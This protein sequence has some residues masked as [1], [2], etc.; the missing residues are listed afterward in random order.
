M[1]T[2]KKVHVCSKCINFFDS[3]SIYIATKPGTMYYTYYCKDC[4]E[5]LNIVDYKTYLKP[6]VSKKTTS[7]EKIVKLKKD[8]I[9]KAK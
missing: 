5:S 3:K 7:K 8:T 2:I 9:K 4:L 1:P 6:R